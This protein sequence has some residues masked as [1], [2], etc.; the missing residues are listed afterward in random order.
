MSLLEKDI[1]RKG[2]VDE[3]V[4]QM[5]FDAGNNEGKEYIVKVIRDSVI[6]ARESEIRHLPGFY[7]LVF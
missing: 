3:N 2:W 1:T 4:R 5:V 7:Y 6:Y